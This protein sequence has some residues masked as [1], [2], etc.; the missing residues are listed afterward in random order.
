[1]QHDTD[2]EV[3]VLLKPIEPDKYKV[4]F[5]NDNVT[6]MQFVIEVLILVFKKSYSEANSIMI[7]THEKGKAVAGVYVYEIAEAKA[8]KAREMAKMKRFPLEVILEQE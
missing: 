7:E 5:L 3:E 4:I 2:E 8:I 1:M 6:T